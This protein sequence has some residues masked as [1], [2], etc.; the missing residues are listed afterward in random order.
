MEE[1]LKTGAASNREQ[2]GSPVTNLNYGKHQ[3]HLS[4]IASL[5]K[6]GSK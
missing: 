3:D 5:T 1:T 6:E 4:L 2:Q